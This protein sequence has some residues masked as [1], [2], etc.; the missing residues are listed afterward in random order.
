MKPSI[1]L[2][3]A[4]TTPTRPEV[5]EAMLPCFDLNFANPSS[6]H[7]PGQQARKTVD[8]CRERIALLLEAPSPECILF[9]SGGTESINLAVKGVAFSL[10]EKGRHII[11]SRIEHAAVLESCAWL[12]HEG[13][14][15]THLP[16]DADGFISPQ[17]L[18]TA[19]R[20]DTVLVSLIHGNNEVGT[21]QNLDALGEVA[22]RHRV[23]F[24]VDAVQTVGKVPLNLSRL[25]VDLLSCSAHKLYGPKGIGF[26]YVSD[27][28]RAQITPWLHGGGQQQGLRS[29]TENIPGIVGLTKA[30]ELA[31]AETDHEAA[32]LRTLQE[33]LITGILEL[34]PSARLNGPR[35]VNLRV[36]GNVNFSFTPVEGEV[37]VLRFD[38]EGI[39]VSSGSACHSSQLQGS[40]VLHGMG[41][42]ENEAR[43]S[44]RFSLGRTT[45]T[46]EIDAVLEALP[47]VLQKAGYF[48]THPETAT[49]M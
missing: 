1:Y 16:A 25:P 45:T 3:Y 32:N 47:R 41:R 38:L 48:R 9:T 17:A 39:R 44:V 13:W 11:T 28:A 20:P 22:R 10:R 27:E 7:Q 29:G 12:S 2:D 24:H 46:R 31:V 26:L 36:P 6:L 4:A 35:D 23:L 30:L 15:I 49:I 5:V 43:S 34:A 21:L 37:L 19:I 18:D 33:K 8:A 40:H 14:E 42:T